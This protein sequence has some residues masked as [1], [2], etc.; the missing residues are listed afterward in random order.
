MAEPPLGIFVPPMFATERGELM[1]RQKE[2]TSPSRREFFKMAG[3]GAGVVAVAGV[4]AKAGE[5]A[6]IGETS[7]HKSSVYRET[8]HVKKYYELARF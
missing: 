6:E 8:S 2:G 3:L 4:S 7:S 5:A 1:K